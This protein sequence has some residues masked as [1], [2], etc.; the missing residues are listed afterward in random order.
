M[1]YRITI[2]LK[3]L[4]FLLI[5]FIHLN[6]KIIRHQIFFVNSQIQTYKFNKD[7]FCFVINFDKYN[8]IY[9]NNYCFST[10]VYIR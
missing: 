10:N 9:I 8:F 2:K 1:K 5:I 7:I 3:H 4:N 6:I